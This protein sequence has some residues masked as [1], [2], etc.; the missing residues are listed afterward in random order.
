MLFYKGTNCVGIINHLTA[1]SK[2][3]W[4]FELITFL[5]R[6]IEKLSGT[7]K[8]VETAECKTEFFES[9]Q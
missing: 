6:N 9:R 4:A 2:N 5:Y 8:K 7:S 3:T 1:R